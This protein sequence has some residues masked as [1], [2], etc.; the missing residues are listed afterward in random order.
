MHL[1][2]MSGQWVYTILTVLAMRL[3]CGTVS[4]LLSTME[5]TVIKA[6]MPLSFACVSYTLVYIVIMY[7]CNCYGKLYSS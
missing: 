2:I 6:M 5:E 7:T 3:Q 4:L 1:L